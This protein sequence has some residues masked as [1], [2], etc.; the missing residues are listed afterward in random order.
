M[1]VSS[2]LFLETDPPTIRDGGLMDC[3]CI[4]SKYCTAQYTF[5]LLLLALL[6]LAHLPAHSYTCPCIRKRL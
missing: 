1:I 4:I 6:A 3:C 5:W 2:W